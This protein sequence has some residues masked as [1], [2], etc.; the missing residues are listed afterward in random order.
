MVAGS[1]VSGL[2]GLILFFYKR[3]R[4][5][6]DSFLVFIAMQRRSIDK[7]NFAI[8]HERS[9]P[10][11]RDS[12]SRVYPFLCLPQR[13]S[14]DDTWREYDTIP[15]D[16]LEQ[17]NESGTVQEI[18]AL[19]DSKLPRTPKPS[20]ILNGFLDRFEKAAK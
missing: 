11:F 18:E 5:P 1:V 13:A 9:R 15:D 4:D 14:I 20:E 12:V 8:W 3:K 7:H 19:D 6:K 16:H 17:D 2:V 10:E